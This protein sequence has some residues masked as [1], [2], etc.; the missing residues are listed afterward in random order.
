MFSRLLEFAAGY[1][2]LKSFKDGETKR[3]LQRVV[4]KRLGKLDDRFGSDSGSG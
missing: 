3:A 4:N 1:F 2:D